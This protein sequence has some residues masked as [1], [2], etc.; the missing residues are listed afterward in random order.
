MEQNKH[1]HGAAIIDIEENGKFKVHNFPIINGK[2][3]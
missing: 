2:V 1:N 3:Y